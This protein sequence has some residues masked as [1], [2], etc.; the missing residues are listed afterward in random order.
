MTRGTKPSNG[1]RHLRL[2]WRSAAI[3]AA[4]GVTGTAALLALSDPAPETSS[5][6]VGNSDAVSVASAVDPLRG[7]LARCRTLS[8]TSDDARCQAAWEVHRRRFMGESRSVTLPPV[9]MTAPR[10]LPTTVTER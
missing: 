2:G 4:V 5:Y 8:A 10:P 9:P 6:A 7:E 3:A 1:R